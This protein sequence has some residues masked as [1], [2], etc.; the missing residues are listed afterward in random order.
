MSKYLFLV[1]GKAD[2]TFLRDCLIQL[3]TKIVIEKETKKEKILR[4]NN[5]LIKI[6]IAGGYTAITGNFKVNIRESYDSKY[7]ILII[8]DADNSEKENGGVEKRNI[9]LEKFKKE[10][11]ISFETFLFPNNK[12]DGNLETLLLQIVNKEKFDKA[13]DC[14]QKYANCVKE[15]TYNDDFRTELLADKSRIF[16]YFRTYNGIKNAKEENRIFDSDYWNFSSEYI[17]PFESFLERI[18]K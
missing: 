4:L 2:A 9:Y 5:D 17:K 12:E 11:G 14:F 18:I 1:E 3:Y 15:I 8:Q 13:M 16:C 6:Q 7:E 10:M